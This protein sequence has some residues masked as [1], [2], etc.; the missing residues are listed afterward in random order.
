MLAEREKAVYLQGIGFALQKI[1]TLLR[2]QFLALEGGQV[3]TSGRNLYKRHS[4]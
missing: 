1:V 3:H 4:I 2:G